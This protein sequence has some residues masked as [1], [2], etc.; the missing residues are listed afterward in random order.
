[1]KKIVGRGIAAILSISV[2]AFVGCAE[3]TAHKPAGTPTKVTPKITVTR[4]ETRTVAAPAVEEPVLDSI[5]Q[6]PRAEACNED[7]DCSILPANPDTCNPCTP[8]SVPTSV[9]KAQ[10]EMGPR[11]DKC[12]AALKKIVD[13]GVCTER[14]ACD[15]VTRTCV[16]V[17]M[18]G[19][20]GTAAASTAPG[21]SFN[22]PTGSYGSQGFDPLN[23]Q[24]LSTPQ[25]YDMRRPYPGGVKSGAFG[26]NAGGNPYSRSPFGNVGGRGG[27]FGSSP[28]G[29]VGGGSNPFAGSQFGGVGGG[30]DPLAGTP[31][32]NNAGGGSNPFGNV[33][34][35]SNPFGAGSQFGNVGGGANQ[36]GKAPWGNVNGGGSQFGRSPFSGGINGGGQNSR[37]AWGNRADANPWGSAQGAGG[38]GGRG[39]AGGGAP[40]GAQLSGGGAGFPGVPSGYGAG[41]NGLNPFSGLKQYPGAGGQLGSYPGISSAR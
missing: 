22:F 2:I 15:K 19:G 20:H 13:S 1:M 37:S 14:P 7:K 9:A 39:Q 10:A 36:F 23:Q 24:N 41:A 17:P 11:K 35:G 28:F 26:G 30:S 27:Q 5:E 21:G 6:S 18:G 40:W 29:N 25:G 31:F 34:G 32:A 33:G 8:D 4:E 16:K 3:P 12:E 38:W